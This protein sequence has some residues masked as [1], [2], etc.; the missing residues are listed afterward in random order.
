MYKKGYKI[1]IVTNCKL[2]KWYDNNSL[3]RFL[4]GGS[5]CSGYST[6]E[7]VEIFLNF[8]NVKIDFVALFTGLKTIIEIVCS[9]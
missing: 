9:F 8:A 2:F 6:K 1:N 7:S 5:Q 3:T 4:L